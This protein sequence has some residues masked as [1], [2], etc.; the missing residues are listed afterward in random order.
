MA[1]PAPTRGGAPHLAGRSQPASGLGQV[2]AD[3]PGRRLVQGLRLIQALRIGRA[4]PHGPY[5]G[6]ESLRKRDRVGSRPRRLITVL[7]VSGRIPPPLPPPCREW[8]GP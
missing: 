2:R 8:S 6:H 1:A 5:E 7:T 3:P 4:S